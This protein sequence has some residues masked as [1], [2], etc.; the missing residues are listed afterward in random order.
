MKNLAADILD[1][2]IA[3]QGGFTGAP[4]GKGLLAAPGNGIGLFA[5][6]ISSTVGLMTIIAIVWFVFVFITGAIGII[7]AGSDKNALESSRK[8]IMTGV[9]GL[10]V[11][12]A[13]VFLINLIGYLL[14]FSNILDLQK[15]FC[16]I[17]TC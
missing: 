5:T 9:I 13:A 8:K 6:F 4:G 2:P 7:G 10:V 1:I 16:S 12:I 17:T 14:G 15:M 3:P 11:T